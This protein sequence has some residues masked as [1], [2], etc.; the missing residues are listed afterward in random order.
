[1]KARISLGGRLITLF[2]LAVSV[3]VFSLTMGFL[4][5]PD[6]IVEGGLSVPM[7]WLSAV[8]FSF[9]NCVYIVS[10]VMLLWMNIRGYA[11]QITEDGIENTICAVNVLCLV[12]ILPVKLI[13]RSGIYRIV[14]EDNYICAKLNTELVSA[15]PIAR[16]ILRRGYHFCTPL[17]S[18]APKSAVDALHMK[19]EKMN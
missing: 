13:P 8:I 1:M 4:L 2:I 10:S 7:K 17:T 5:H 14:N 11:Y 6:T 3:G 16:L 19:V 12:I 9:I 15:S 18:A